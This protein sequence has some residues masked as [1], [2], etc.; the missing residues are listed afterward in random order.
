M[1]QV[2]ATIVKFAVGGLALLVAAS[3]AGCAAGAGGNRDGVVLNPLGDAQAPARP[4]VAA[5]LDAS[6][7]D[8]PD[9]SQRGRDVLTS[10]AREGRLEGPVVV[11]L[12]V[13]G[14]GDATAEGRRA[15]VVGFLK[16]QGMADGQ[17]EVMAVAGGQDTAGVSPTADGGSPRD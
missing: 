9:L 4:L 8:G 6:H 5:T 17:F 16:Q 15:A 7:F 2:I 1:T 12:A 14:D 13:P 10:L 11:N 3:A